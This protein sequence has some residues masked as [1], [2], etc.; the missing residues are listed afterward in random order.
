MIKIVGLIILFVFFLFAFW[1]M[2]KI[3]VEG[4]YIVNKKLKKAGHKGNYYE[5]KKFMEKKNKKNR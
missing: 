2:L 1:V 4:N 3:T 5:Y